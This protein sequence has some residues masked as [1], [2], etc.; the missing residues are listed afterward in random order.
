M[1]KSALFFDIDGTLTDN[2]TG[3]IRQSAMDAI[4][5]ARKNGHMA[6]INTGRTICSIQPEIRAFEFDGFLCGCGTYLLVHNEVVFW[7]SLEEERKKEIIEKMASCKIDGVLEGVDDIYFSTNASR[8]REIE[9]MRQLYGKRGLGHKQVEQGKSVPYD[10]MFIVTDGLSDVKTF[11][12][13]INKDMDIIDRGRG[14]YEIVPKGFSKATAIEFIRNK[15]G[16]DM[17]QIY[18]F[19]DSANDLPMFQYAKHTVAMGEHAEALK[20]Y[21]EFITKKVEEDGIS[22]AM[23]YY[24]LI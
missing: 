22:Y 14:R 19:G 9:F 8:T 5:Q 3:I 1:K 13:Y 17:E 7:N 23:K 16:M 24:G 4:A 11:F 10:K 12:E 21:T 15:L 2:H 6:F 20:P 18:V